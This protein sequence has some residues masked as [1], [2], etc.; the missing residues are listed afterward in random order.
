MELADAVSRYLDWRQ[1]K[2]DLAALSFKS[3]A[4]DLAALQQFLRARHISELASLDTEVLREW[5][6]QQA[7]SGLSATTL[8]RRVSSVR[9]FTKWLFDQGLTDADWGSTLHQPK[10]P[11]R[12]PRVLTESQ[13]SEMLEDLVARADSGDPIAV[14]NVAIVELLYASALR[15]SELCG[16]NVESVDFSER[17]IRIVGKGN[18]ERVAPIG[19]PA[20]E[21]LQRYLE[22][23]G[24]LVTEHSGSALFLSRQGRRVNPR[25]VYELMAGLLGEHPG[26]GPRGP[27]T[28]RHSAATHLL[29]HGADLRSVQEMLG[30]RSLA[31]TEL[32]THVSVERL[33]KAYEQAHPRA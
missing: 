27:H 2:R 10:A 18:R 13:I 24:N 9:G 4:A 25:A 6:W 20:V 30:H 12:L 22:K 1:S 16:A 3:Y 5:L 23:R 33:K 14:R 32:Y 7:S 29:D 26:A 11:K 19:Q 17:A 21:A 8:R 15:V 28:L 31:T